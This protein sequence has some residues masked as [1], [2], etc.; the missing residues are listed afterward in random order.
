[1]LYNNLKVHRILKNAR[2]AYPKPTV[3]VAEMRPSHRSRRSWAQS[4]GPQTGDYPLC[5]CAARRYS[6]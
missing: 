2:A 4:L 5:L 3:I 6:Q 1:M